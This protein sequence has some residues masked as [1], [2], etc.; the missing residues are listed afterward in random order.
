MEERSRHRELEGK[1][2]QAMGTTPQLEK[3]Y[4]V[5]SG[6]RHWVTSLQFIERVSK[7]WPQDF[8]ILPVDSLERIPI[9]SPVK[10]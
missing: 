5:R 7:T 1:F 9:G 8:E 4:L 2:I 6:V 3:I 10:G